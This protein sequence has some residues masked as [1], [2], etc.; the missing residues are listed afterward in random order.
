MAQLRL[1]SLHSTVYHI[2]VSLPSGRRVVLPSLTHFDFRGITEY[3]EDLVAGIDAPRLEDIKVALFDESFFHFSKLS[4]F[5]DRIEMHKSHR[6]ADI[7][8]SKNTISISLIQSGAPTRL[9]FRF[10]CE[11]LSKQLNLIA[12]ICISFSAFLFNV[13]DLRISTTQPSSLRDHEAWVKIIHHFR[14]TKWLHVADGH[15]TNFVRALQQPDRQ[16]KTVLP[17]LHKLYIWQP[18]PR[19]APLREAVV[20]FVTSR[21]L[22]GHHIAVEYEQSC[23]IGEL[24][25]TGLFTPWGTIE[26]LPDDIL[27]NIF[28]YILDASSQF[29][30]TLVHV[31]RRWRQIIFTSPLGLDLRL[32]CTYGTPVLRTLECWPPLPLVVNYGGSPML[33]PPAPEDE[34]NIMAALKQ[35]DRISSVN[36][37]VTNSLLEK[38]S[39]I[40]EPFSEL[41][42]LVLLSR[43]KLQLTLPSAFRWGARLRTLHSTRIAIPALPQLL[44][45]STG[46]VDLQLH[47]IPSVGYFSPRSVRECVVRDGPSSITFT[48]FPFPPPSPKLPR[49]ASTVRGARYALCSHL[50]QISR[51]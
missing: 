9:K 25:G 1:L 4:E 11:G 6:R 7:K 28:L 16:R 51:N 43:D 5:V 21:R 37:T 35:S 12:R 49:L 44:S 13:E 8:L 24:R 30:P 47:E 50:P 17:A 40:S 15:S 10:F 3:L 26:T 32:Y 22:S 27:L 33:A 42:Q 39:T 29:W 48:S 14:G 19:Y 2:G 34:E 41:E 31:S 20:S 36:L 45:P 18:G 38:L 23:D 46:L